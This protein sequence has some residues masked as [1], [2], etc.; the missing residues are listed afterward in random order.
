MLTKCLFTIKRCQILATYSPNNGTS[1]E[2]FKRR[3][4]WDA[5][6]TAF[7]AKIHTRAIMKPPQGKP[8]VYVGDL[9]CAATDADL[10]HPSYFRNIVMDSQKNENVLPGTWILY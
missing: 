9:N 1:E 8:L 4:D 7:V 10:S 3:S 2:S 6:V 5:S